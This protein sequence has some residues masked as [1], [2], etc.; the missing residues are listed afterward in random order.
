MN[1]IF[2]MNI[3]V[4]VFSSTNVF[5]QVSGIS[6]S[7]VVLPAT[8][9]VAAGDFEFGPSFDVFWSNQQWNQN[10]KTVDL[11]NTNRESGLAY[12][13]TSGFKH[14]IE[15]GLIVTEDVS[16][17]SFGLKWL[18]WK[19]DDKSFAFQSG[20]N[21]ESGNRVINETEESLK[22]LTNGII[23]TFEPSE[24]L[25]IDT[26]A[27]FSFYSTEIDLQS[28]NYSGTFDI[29]AGYLLTS[30][31]QAIVELN[32]TWLSF[33][34]SFYNSS[35]TNGTLGFTFYPNDG[36]VVIFGVKQ[37]LFG[38]NNAKGISFIGAFTFL[39]GQ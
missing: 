6:N 21:F 14:N 25:S 7:K 17:L 36:V 23:F 16:S 10:G 38:S 31:F 39:M 12:R 29:G 26:D 18:F 30:Q 15:A 3:V 34:N 2:I 22:I 1:K 5:S 13:F 24:K 9:T 8:G 32:S 4:A 20:V 35:K 27:T 19:N 33:E 28:V 11:N 37:D